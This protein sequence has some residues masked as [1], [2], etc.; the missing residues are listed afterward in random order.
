MKISMY[1][2]ER[3][4]RRDGDETHAEKMWDDKSAVFY[5]QTEKIQKEFANGF[6][7]K[8]IKERHILNADSKV[9]DI[10]CG[11]GRHLLEFSKYTQHLTG[12]DI[13][14]KMLAYAKEKLAHI[15]QAHLVHGNWTEIFTRENEFDLAFACMTP[16]VSSVEHLRRMSMISKKCM[17]E[18]F[19]YQKDC[20]QEEIEQLIGRKLFNLP[21]NDK[22]YVYGVWNILWHSGYFPQVF[23]DTREDTETHAVE[24]YTRGIKCNDEEKAA[25]VNLVAAKA[26]DGTVTA[27]E[28][29]TKA[30]VLWET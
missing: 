5:E 19:V 12:I 22:D 14:S 28:R 24:D 9:L 15:P 21:H 11:T 3:F 30:V 13:S 23:F 18:R 16:A 29:V 25:I 1:D 26:T 6:V 4:I 2:F 8:L 10:G 20:I 27:T 7:F 17:L